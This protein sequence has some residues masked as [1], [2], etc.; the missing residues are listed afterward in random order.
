MNIVYLDNKVFYKRY[1]PNG[2]DLKPYQQWS[3]IVPSVPALLFQMPKT[4][5]VNSPSAE[6][7]KIAPYL[8]NLFAQILQTSA[9]GEF[10]EQFCMKF[11]DALE[12]D[13]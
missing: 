13:K 1:G 12:K 4:S 10:T 2:R 9:E 11:H 6:V 8:K 5:S 7:C 3:R